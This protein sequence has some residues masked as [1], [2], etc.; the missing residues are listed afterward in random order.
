MKVSVWRFVW[1]AD[2]V[3]SLIARSLQNKERSMGELFA[4]SPLYAQWVEM[5]SKLPAAPDGY[6][7]IPEF[8]ADPLKPDT[9]TMT[10]R[11]IKTV[12]FEED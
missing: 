5:R 10:A 1:S 4:T 8:I 2:D 11:L 3:S 12:R 7:Y 6:H 9:I